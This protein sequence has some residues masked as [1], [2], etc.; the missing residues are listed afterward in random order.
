MAVKLDQIVSQV[1]EVIFKLII[2]Q[3]FILRFVYV[4]NFR[5]GFRMYSR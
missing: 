2:I 4:L 5:I 1:E 3:S